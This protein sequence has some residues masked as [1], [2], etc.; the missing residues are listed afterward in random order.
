MTQQII[1]AH[2]HGNQFN[3]EAF[4]YVLIEPHHPTQKFVHPKSEFARFESYLRVDGDKSRL[5]PLT[6]SQYDNW[7]HY[8]LSYSADRNTLTLTWHDDTIV[9]LHDA[10]ELMELE[11]ELSE[12][13]REQHEV[14]ASMA[15]IFGNIAEHALSS[16]ASQPPLAQRINTQ[17]AALQRQINGL[18][19]TRAAKLVEYNEFFHRLASAYAQGLGSGRHWNELN[20]TRARV[21]ADYVC[22]LY[23]TLGADTDADGLQKP[24][25]TWLDPRSRVVPKKR[26]PVLTRAAAMR[27]AEIATKNFAVGH[28]DNHWKERERLPGEYDD[29]P[30]IV[31]TDL[32][33]ADLE[34]AIKEADESRRDPAKPDTISDF[35]ATASR[36][37]SERPTAKVALVW[38]LPND[39]GSPITRI[40]V[41]RVNAARGA[42]ATTTQL[43]ADAVTH[44]V[45]GLAAGTWIFHVRAVNALG[46]ADWANVR[47]DILDV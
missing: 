25:A 19:E 20:K 36:I 24:K 47:V 44:N 22:E 13:D 2:Q 6:Q 39:G 42:G 18:H 33:K 46:N 10:D 21:I 23:W 30:K 11:V 9:R 35:R 15:V 40:E 41:Q 38:Q 28:E 34:A 1:T 16:K 26:L 7:E 29:L 17:A 4:F 43:A 5:Y 37:T 27:L 32:G 45:A 3:A 14:L 31:L 8:D 12:R